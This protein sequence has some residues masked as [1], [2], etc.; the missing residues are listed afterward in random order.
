MGYCTQQDLVDRFGTAELVQLTDRAGEGQIDT[1][2]VDRAI[3]DAAGEID[4]YVTAAG[5]TPPLDPVPAV[6][7]AYGCDIVRYRLY[8]D[9]ATE[10]VSKR[11]DDA[12]RF[13]RLLADRKV[14]LDAREPEPGVGKVEM[15][16]G[17]K[18]FGGGGF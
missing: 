8:D 2:V 14:R 4:G 3:A 7:V 15:D 1:D 17:R 16:G 6:L 9:Q 5:Y 11:Y 12:V 13:L 18:V 10:Q